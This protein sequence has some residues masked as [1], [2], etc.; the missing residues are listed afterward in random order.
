MQESPHDVLHN[1][2]GTINGE[3]FH[4]IFDLIQSMGN[5]VMTGYDN[6]FTDPAFMTGYDNPFTEPAFI[7]RTGQA[8]KRIIKAR[9][10]E[11]QRRKKG[12]T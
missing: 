7:P 12:R 1:Q 11:R 4:S 9:K 2:G 3:H 5:G 6:P 10:V 8:K